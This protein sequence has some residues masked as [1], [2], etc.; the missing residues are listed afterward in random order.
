MKR[1]AVFSSLL[2]ALAVCA[3]AAAQDVAF[4]TLFRGAND[5]SRSPAGERVI[6]SQQEFNDAGLNALIPPGARIAIDWDTQMVVAVFMGMQSTGG[7]AVEVT[8]VH[9]E[10][11]FGTMPGQPHPLHFGWE[12]VVDVRRTSPG[13]GDMVTM[14]LTSPFHVITLPKSDDPVRFQDVASNLTFDTLTRSKAGIRDGSSI[15][16]ESG[17]KV[18]VVF[19]SH[20]MSMSYSYEGALE[21]GELSRLERGL[22]TANFYDLAP[23]LD[24]TRPSPLGGHTWTYDLEGGPQ[25]DHRVSGHSVNWTQD[26]RD[27]MARVETT[28]DEIRDRIIRDNEG[29]FS[30]LTYSVTTPTGGDWLTVSTSIDKDGNVTVNQAYRLREVFFVPVNGQAD[31]SDLQALEFAVRTA[32]LDSIPGQLPTPVHITEAPTFNLDV[33]SAVSTNDNE[34]SGEPGYLTTYERR[35]QPIF[36]AVDRIKASVLNQGPEEAKGTVSVRNGEVFLV[37]S[38]SMQ[39]RITDP[40]IAAIVRH[41]EGRTVKV[42]GDVTNTGRF[43]SDVAATSIV[44]PERVESQEGFVQVNGRRAEVSIG[45][46]APFSTVP[47]FGPAARALTL[48]DG[49]M[50]TFDGYV[51]ADGYGTALEVFVSSVEGTA[52][53]FAALTRRGRWAGFVYG[54]QDVKVLGLSRSGAYARVFNGWSTGYMPVRKLRVGEIIFTTQPAPGPTPSRGLVGGVNDSTND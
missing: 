26:I 25:G 21:R 40:E 8:N 44:H 36:D 1:S 17:G 49:R 11:V 6:K 9:R 32:R 48:A 42:A 50:A 18:T 45:M 47:T 54:G 34:I 5:S 35:L 20:N 15:E 22:A 23:N 38:R 2:L 3:P 10:S 7:Y 27:R 52:T 41:W 33:N 14:A 16:V 30:D 43:S 19:R 12:L 39:Y 31:P 28:L 4:D 37:E 24:G 51:F 13:P 29:V 53:S 46:T